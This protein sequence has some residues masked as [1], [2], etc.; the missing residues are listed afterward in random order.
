MEITQNICT[1]NFVSINVD[2]EMMST[3]LNT[4]VFFDP[5]SQITMNIICYFHL[6]EIPLRFIFPDPVLCCA[7]HGSNDIF[8]MRETNAIL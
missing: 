8:N 2:A 7:F 1:L 5:K 3:I 4:K 6:L